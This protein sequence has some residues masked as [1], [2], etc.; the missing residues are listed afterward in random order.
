MERDAAITQFAQYLQRRFPERRTV[1]DYCSDVRQFAATCVKPWRDVTMH[2]I[3]DFVDHQRQSG[4]K[5]ATINRRVAA[6]KTFFD[7]LAEDSGELQWP[8]PVRFKRH[9]GKRG[10]QLPRDL[11]DAT[12]AQLWQAITA[13]RDR[14]WFV[15]MWRGGLRVGEVVALQVDALL[16]PAQGD[17]PARL[18]VCG[19]GR[20]ERVILL[21]ADAYAV[22]DTWLAARPECGKP[23]LFLNEHGH[24]LT[25]NGIEWL[26]RGYGTAIGQHVT[27]HQ[28]RHTYARQLT[29]AGMPLPSLS[30]LMGHAQ[31]TTTQIYTAGA[32][33]QL[34]QAYQT[35]VAHLAEPAREAPAAP[36]A[37][38]PPLAEP[39]APEPPPLP[40]WAAWG[41]HLPAA[42]RQAS[43]DYV[44]RHL[45][46]WAAPRRRQRALSVLNE[47]ALL[48]AWFLAQRP[49]THPGEISLKDLWA[50]QTAHQAAGHAAGTINRRLDYLLGILRELAE[51]DLPVDNS[52]FRLRPLPRPASL[53][54]HLTEAESQRLETFLAQRHTA[55]DPVVRLEN[56]CVWLLLHSGLRRGE[57]VDLRWGDLDLA[58]QRLIVRQG[59]GQKDRLVYLSH[60]T[61]QALHSY[62]Q[63]AGL[64]A[65]DPLWRLPNGQPMT[66]HWLRSHLAAIGRHLQIE[67]FYPHRLRHTCATRLLNAGMDIVH[68]QKLLGHEQLSTTMIY[69]RVQNPTVERDYRQAMDQIERRQMPLSDQPIAVI[70]WPMQPT[71]A[72]VELDNSV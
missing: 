31:I 52:V 39:T 24:P 12:V 28:L 26:L 20:Q 50:Y 71:D 21:S 55:A 27:P 38:A 36:V 53:P 17:Q 8:N 16:S 5:P 15:L 63:G 64:H 70:D 62:L 58:G 69:A 56:A 61:C 66:D 1:V 43:L 46:T 33:P 68:I 35:A 6:L 19:K 18:R 67:P 14:A 22:L 45:Y 44:Q 72:W 34:A 4:L 30:K 3:D 10:R 42:I 40:D 9:A 49:L 13:P 37:C 23:H 47:L 59:K 29:E 11:S 57:C 41:G 54:R 60:V 25:A 65:S 32:D 7:F 51:H 48:W 2:D